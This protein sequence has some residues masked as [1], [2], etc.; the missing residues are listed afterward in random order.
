MFIAA[1]SAIAKLWKESKCPFSDEWIKKKWCIYIM[2]YYSA[3]KKNEILPLATTWMD[4]KSIILS[5]ISQRQIPYDFTYVWNPKNK[6]NKQKTQ[7]DS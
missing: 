7:I 3:I 6:T 2:D 1:L 4:V 5:E